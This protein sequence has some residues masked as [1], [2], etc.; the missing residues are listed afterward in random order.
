MIVLCEPKCYNNMHLLFNSGLLETLQIAYPQHQIHYFAEKEQAKQV[1]SILGNKGKIVVHPVAIM[2]FKFEY[3]FNL[4]GLLKIMY[5][6]WKIKKLPELEAVY[7][8]STS[9]TLLWCSRYMLKNYK[10]HYIFHRITST[11]FHSYSWI[12]WNFYLIKAINC[13]PNY[14]K[15]WVLGKYVIKNANKI[16]PQLK[17]SFLF[18]PH[19]LPSSLQGKKTFYQENP[20]FGSIGHANLEK[21]SQVLFELANKP[22][23]RTSQFFHIGTIQI[24][25]YKKNIPNVKTFHEQEFYKQQDLIKKLIPIN[26]VVF[27]Y[28][29][30]TYQLHVSGAAFEAL[31]A[32]KPI[33]AIVNPFFE[34]LFEMWG[35]I[36]YLEP[37]FEALEVRIS[38][39]IG[40]PE[41]TIYQ[42]QQANIMKCLSN[43]SPS[44]VAKSIIIS[45][46]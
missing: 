21:A 13:L 32:L 4:S 18:I 40:N 25:R 11:L 39:I 24:E 45:N 2:D 43:I 36:G 8:S 26:Y 14:H 20:T 42:I 7:F 1:M 30:N 38:S 10:V 46:K 6:L 41:P 15:I 9:P 3:L 17:K 31:N 35:N 12:H 33:I 34:E 23:F 27:S 16:C 22:K 28:P 5:T 37:T 19:V 44:S 29:S